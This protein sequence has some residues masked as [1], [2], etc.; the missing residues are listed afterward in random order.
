MIPPE[1]AHEVRTAWFEYGVLLTTRFRFV[2]QRVIVKA[3]MD[4]ILSPSDT[5]T[6][7]AFLEYV[8]L[9]TRILRSLDLPSLRHLPPCRPSPELALPQH[10]YELSRHRGSEA[11]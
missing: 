2:P 7:R 1:L 9:Q 10:R 3:P 6:V 8:R 11:A 4:D 5:L